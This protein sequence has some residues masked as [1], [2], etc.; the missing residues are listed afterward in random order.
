MFLIR[1]IHLKSIKNRPDT[2]LK[3]SQQANEDII[4]TSLSQKKNDE[5]L[6]G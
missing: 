4:Q 3:N 6:S 5:D 2:I 1:L